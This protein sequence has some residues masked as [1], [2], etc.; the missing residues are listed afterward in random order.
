MVQNTPVQWYRVL[1]LVCCRVLSIGVYQLY[2]VGIELT[3]GDSPSSCVLVVVTKLS[4]K[5]LDLT[6][7]QFRSLSTNF[8]SMDMNGAL[9]LLC[10]QLLPSIETVTFICTN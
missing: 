2:T 5:A 6:I 8:K 10:V 9:E 7:L 4:R 3:D 1:L